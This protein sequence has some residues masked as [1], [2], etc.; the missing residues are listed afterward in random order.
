MLGIIAGNGH[1]P[2]IVSEH[3]L[4]KN[5]NGKVFV[6]SLRG[7]ADESL[8]ANS[9]NENIILKSFEIGKVG[10]IVKFF[11]DNHVK[12]LLM[13][14][15]VKRPDQKFFSFDF[16]GLYWYFQLREKFKKGDDSL[17]VGLVELLEKD[18]FMVQSICD[19]Y[20]D[21]IATDVDSTDKLP[22]DMNEKDIALGCRFLD[23]MSEFDIG[24]SVIVQD[25][26]VIGIEA[27]EG[28]DALIRRIATLKR[29][30]KTNGVLVKRAKI[31]Q[32]IYAD[33]PTIGVET[34]KNAVFANLDGIAVQRNRT[35]IVNKPEV[36]RLAKENGLFIS[37]IP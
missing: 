7:F 32:T 19:V 20:A 18:G 11:K 34:I 2:Y 10:K 23:K 22:S 30:S 13:I 12:K 16:K 33:L 24:Q 26:I 4:S 14:G 21:G 17:L 15:G 29:R 37:V 25:G 9:H 3:F 35:I 31:G 27:V 28:T 1:L 6:A 5:E 8:F 36:F